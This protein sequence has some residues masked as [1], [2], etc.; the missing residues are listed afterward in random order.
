M[1]RHYRAGKVHCVSTQKTAHSLCT[2]LLTMI[3]TILARTI[4]PLPVPLFGSVKTASVFLCA[5]SKAVPRMI[6]WSVPLSVGA[7]WF[8]WPAVDDGWK[9]SMGLKKEVKAV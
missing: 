8:V 4:H 5:K 7:L 1:S 6:G 3:Q 2:Y 9:Q